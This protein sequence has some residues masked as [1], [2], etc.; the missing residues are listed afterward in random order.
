MDKYLEKLQSKGVYTFT[1]DDLKKNLPI[2]LAGINM[3]ISRYLKRGKIARVKSGFYVIVPPEYKK[4]GI[5]P[6]FW[7]A[8]DLMSYIDSEYYV[9]LSSAAAIYGASHQQARIF[10]IVSAKQVKDIRV[11]NLKINFISKNKIEPEKYIRSKKTETGKVKISSPELT[12]FDLVRYISQSGGINS[13]T[14][15]LQ[16]L[17][18]EIEWKKLFELAD[19]YK[20]AIYVQ[21]L[22]YLFEYLGFAESAVRLNEWLEGKN[23]YPV[24]LV[25]D[26]RRKSL[27]MDKKWKVLINRQV[28]SAV[29]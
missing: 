5:L 13:V 11:K 10:Q 18:E 17:H 7:F 16:E 14:T 23:S 1:R 9:G 2:S 26:K 20:K 29:Q 8:D 24:Y 27:R 6:P 25:P 28:E 19:Y 15:V 12:C 3:S 4:S 22:G 21:R